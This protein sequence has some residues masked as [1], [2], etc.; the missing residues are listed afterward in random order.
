MI[1]DMK[2]ENPGVEK[3]ILKSAENVNCDMVI[4]YQLGGVKHSFLEEFND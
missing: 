1:A 4:G 3:S 2:K